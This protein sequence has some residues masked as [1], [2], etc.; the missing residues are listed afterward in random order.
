MLDVKKLNCKIKLA[1]ISLWIE[2]LQ[3]KDILSEKEK[4][5][6]SIICDYILEEVSK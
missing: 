1:I 5:A 4:E 3:K 2:Q 6:T